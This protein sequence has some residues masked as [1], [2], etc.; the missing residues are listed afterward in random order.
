MSSAYPA[1][2]DLSNLFEDTELTDVTFAVD[3]QRFSAHRC[4]LAAWS[5]YFNG[6]FKSGK[7]MSECGGRS[8]GEDIVIEEVSAGTFRAL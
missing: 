2:S 7:G 4:V 6:L 5:P 3:R 1:F 8:A